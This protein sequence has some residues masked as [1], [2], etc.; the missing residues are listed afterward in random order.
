MALSSPRH[1]RAVLN[2]LKFSGAQRNELRSLTDSEWKEILSHWGLLR[3]TLP[4]RH[5]CS[6]DL[7]NW[8]RA[9]IDENIADNAERCRRIKKAYLEIANA[10]R[11][12]RVE[13]LVLKG[14]AQWPAY[15]QGPHLRTQTD[16][17]C[18]CPTE[19]IFRARD[20][21]C[22]LGYQ[23][24][25][26]L[27]PKL[28]D[29]LPALEKQIDWQWRGNHFDPDIP[30][31]V[32]L[33]FQ[34][35]N[36]ASTRLRPTGLEQFW[37][38][39]IERQLDGF[40]CPALCEVDAAAYSALHM[41][42]NLLVGGLTPHNV[43][44]IAWFLHTNTDDAAFWR[45]RQELH[46]ASLRLLEAVCF[47]LAKEWFACR[48]PEDVEEET[49]S[50]PT[51]VKQWF[52]TYSHSPLIA[53]LRPNKDVL[54]LHLSLLESPSDRRSILWKSFVP[55]PMRPAEPVKHWTV[56]TYGI[57]IIRAISRVP[58]HLRPVPRMLWHG[59]HRWRSTK[60]MGRRI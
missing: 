5:I 32:E 56:R 48:L 46:H 14:F 1:F 4:L 57:F 52:Q 34:F 29:H 22:G 27:K 37:S 59:L 43:Y 58:H 15:M 18:F 11:E 30:A 55:M 9:Q 23:W 54:W 33:H 19:A 7:P 41:L 2:A 24:H 50:L 60:N 17:D 20:V 44:E 42:R 51:G 26:G 49:R 47:K 6:D 53:L 13:H 10:L 31:P 8:V 21:V 3:L 39:R 28:T 35:W 12:A 16:I 36:E 45:K 40:A 25:E 38:R